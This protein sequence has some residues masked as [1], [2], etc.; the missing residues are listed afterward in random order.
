MS[1]CV[2]LLNSRFLS[3][4]SKPT[5]MRRVVPSTSC[6]PT[7]HF[8]LCAMPME[9]T[10]AQSPRV[11]TFWDIGQ[12]QWTNAS[13]MTSLCWQRCVSA[14]LP[15]CMS[16][17]PKILSILKKYIDVTRCLCWSYLSCTNSLLGTLQIPSSLSRLWSW[18]AI[19]VKVRATSDESARCCS[20][21][22]FLAFVDF[23][24]QHDADITEAMKE[25]VACWGKL[26]LV[27]RTFF[28]L[29][30]PQKN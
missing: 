1:C 14:L 10:L 27:S 26:H 2:L 22:L 24:M 16:N 13:P 4:P 25:A 7:A 19:S 29:L 20:R 21:R 11:L 6:G 15:P 5:C 17:P 18:L 8:W 23:K 28:Y 12:Q 30:P 3:Q 9:F